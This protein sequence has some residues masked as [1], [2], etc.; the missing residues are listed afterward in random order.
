MSKVNQKLSEILPHIEEYQKHLQSN[1]TE[2]ARNCEYSHDLGFTVGF[3][4]GTKYIKIYHW[5]NDGSSFKQRSC[6]SFVDYEGNIWK[7]ASWKAPAKNF[8]RGNVKTKDYGTI[9]W[10]GC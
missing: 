7:A 2:N 9:R 4:A 10:T 6:H 5:Y 1:Y 3:E 8:P